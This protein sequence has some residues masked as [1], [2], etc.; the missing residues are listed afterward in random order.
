MGKL[1]W[2]KIPGLIRASGRILEVRML[3]TDSYL[4]ALHG[5]LLEEAAE[6]RSAPTPATALA[7]VQR[8]P[9]RLRRPRP[10]QT[11]RAPRLHQATLAGKPR[12]TPKPA[13][14]D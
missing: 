1:V 8:H 4:T 14:V 6:L 5:K 3:D 2:D 13:N 11:L 12:V 7:D 9:P 10:T